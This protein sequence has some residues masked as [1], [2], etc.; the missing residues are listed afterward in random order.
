MDDWIEWA[1]RQLK[2]AVAAAPATDN[3]APA[4]IHQ[5]TVL[6]Q[7]LSA[8][9]GSS[10]VPGG[11]APS[12]ADLVVAPIAKCALGFFGEHEYVRTN[13]PTCACLSACQPPFAR[14]RRSAL[15]R[16]PHQ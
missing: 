6:E 3:A 2:P 11:S 14:S 12:L 16:N 1:F 10:L 5:L 13:L 4:L 9:Q 15:S 7:A 8:G